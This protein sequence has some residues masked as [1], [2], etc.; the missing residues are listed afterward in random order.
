MFMSKL[1]RKFNGYEQVWYGISCFQQFLIAPQ[2]VSHQ[3][4]VDLM[5]SS[6][7]SANWIKPSSLARSFI[8]YLYQ[9]F[10]TSQGWDRLSSTLL[11]HFLFPVQLDYC[12]Q[13]K[14]LCGLNVQWLF[15]LLIYMQS[16]RYMIYA[17]KFFLDEI[18]KYIISI[19]LFAT[20]YDDMVVICFEF[21][22]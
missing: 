20:A 2:I 11:W 22:L 13:M 3:F 10:S 1:Q 8:I 9:L 6:S 15:H 16:R 12:N 21:V 4:L 5:S 14:C 18:L 7:S 19:M 17:I